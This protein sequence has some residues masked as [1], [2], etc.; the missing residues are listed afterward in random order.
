MFKTICD[1]HNIVSNYCRIKKE[2][3]D[4]LSLCNSDNC[5]NTC[6]SKHRN[7][8]STVCRDHNY[9]QNYFKRGCQLK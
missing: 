5:N 4:V 8:I 3:D 1:D 2:C 7:V 9:I 6:H